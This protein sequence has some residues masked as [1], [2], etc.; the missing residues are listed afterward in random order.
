VIAQLVPGGDDLSTQLGK[1]IELLALQEKRGLHTVPS[2]ELEQRRSAF[3]GGAIVQRESDQGR[4]AGRSGH[5][6]TEQLEGSAVG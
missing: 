3:G 1:A 2:Q 4:A 5:Q 6:V